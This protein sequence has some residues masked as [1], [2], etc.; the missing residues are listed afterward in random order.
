MSLKEYIITRYGTSV[1][2][3]TAKLKDVR[4]IQAKVKNQYIFLQ[5]CIAH[6][7]IPKSLRIKSP[8]KTKRGNE[9]MVRCRFELLV[10]IK[11]DTKRKYFST[12]QKV[13]ELIRKLRTVLSTEDMD[14]VNSVTNI[15]R[16]KMFIK[17]K[18]RLFK[19][20]DNLKKLGKKTATSNGI[21]DNN[22]N[23]ERDTST[24][25]KNGVLNLC[26]DDVK[27][28]HLNLLNLGPKFVPRSKHIPWMD[29]VAT[30][31]SPALKLEYSNKTEEAR[32]LRKNI[33]RV[34]KRNKTAK[35]NLTKTQR[36]ARNEIK[37]DKEISIYSVD[38]G[39]GFVRIKTEEAREENA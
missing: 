7:L 13:E 26:N 6:K 36:I 2:N 5:R 8:V 9:I 21:M 29:I 24:H 3:D 39:S 20:F 31:E 15:A 1:Y 37:K 4:K 34:L 35:D 38:K 10:S 28:T 18:E 14:K 17:S 30:T 27:D 32:D 25:L 11:N 16:E 22:N 12:F 33:L 23:E 19:K